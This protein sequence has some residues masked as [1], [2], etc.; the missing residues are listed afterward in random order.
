MK[1][2]SRPLCQP[3]SP[4]PP[5][6]VQAAAEKNTASTDGRSPASV[7]TQPPSPSSARVSAGLVEVVSGHVTAGLSPATG[8]VLRQGDAVYLQEQISTGKSSE[9]RIRLDTADVIHLKSESQ[10]TIEGLRNAQ[11]PTVLQLLKGKIRSQVVKPKD[12]KEKVYE[13][14]TRSAVAG[15]R[16]TDFVAS[17]ERAGRE[18]TT[19]ETLE[20][21]VVLYGRKTPQ[22]YATVDSAH[23]ASYVVTQWASAETGDDLVLAGELTP[24]VVISANSMHQLHEDT[25]VGPRPEKGQRDIASH[26]ICAKPTGRF[27]QCAW[28][29]VGNPAHEKHCRTDLPNVAC[30]RTRCNANGVWADETQ[31]PTKFSHIC[32]PE[33]E[34]VGPCDY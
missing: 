21:A 31:L 27:N 24:V 2:C 29:C 12:R 4:L 25:Y 26:P 15:V 20:G 5:A 10:F 23:T 22:R 34:K 18:R 28:R 7:A 32:A 14:K 33:K 8:R 13:V 17:F 3:K 19:V 11:E 1:S 6:C 30:M 9:V 16:G